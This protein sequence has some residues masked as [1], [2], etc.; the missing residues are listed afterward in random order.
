MVKAGIIQSITGSGII[1]A[2][3][4]QGQT[5]TLRQG[6]AVY[7]G[8]VLGT[9]GNISVVVAN[10]NGDQ[11]AS[12]A[13]NAR[14][15]MEE[16]MFAR[17][18]EK[19]STIHKADQIQAALDQGKQIADEE[20]AVGDENRFDSDTSDFHE[21]DRSAG[22]VE[23]RALGAGSQ[24]A[25]SRVSI[26]ETS[27]NDQIESL[28]AFGVEVDETNGLDTLS[29]KISVE[30][31]TAGGSLV[32]SADGATWDDTS[33]TLTDDLGRWQIVLDQATGS[34]TFTQLVAE[35]HGDDGNDH[36]S[37][38]EYAITVTATNNDGNSAE[39]EFKVGIRD[40]GPS[41]IA[42]DINQGDFI[43][44]NA[45]SD[46][47]SSDSSSD[48]VL[49]S[50]DEGDF[51]TA[52]TVL[53]VAE[54]FEADFGQDGSGSITYALALDLTQ[55]TD[56]VGSQVYAHND[57]QIM[58]QLVN[59]QIIGFEGDT[60]YFT[61]SINE[62]G[63]LEFDQLEPVKHFGI[64]A[65]EDSVSL[66]LNGISV[67]AVITDSD[68][69]T[70]TAA[71]D[72]SDYSFSILDDA[73]AA[74]DDNYDVDEDGT[75]IVDPL[76]VFAN[77]EMGGD[78]SQLSSYTMP[79]HGSLVLNEDGSFTYKPD[80]DFNGDD[81][82]TYTLTD[83]DGDSST[84]TVN[85]TVNEINDPPQ[86]LDKFISVDEANQSFIMSDAV[87]DPDD[88]DAELAITINN[89][90]EFGTLFYTDA[91][92]NQVEITGVIS[93][94]QA[95]FDSLIYVADQDA[96]QQE[97]IDFILGTTETRG[98]IS[99]WGT[100]DDKGYSYSSS[101]GSIKAVVTAVD[102]DG[103]AAKVGFQ[104]S[105]NSEKGVG[106]GVKGDIGNGQINGNK[107][108]ET[109]T[110]VLNFYEESN[111]DQLAS[112]TNVTLGFSGLGGYFN[113]GASQ[114]AHVHWVAKDA[115][116]NIVAQGYENK[117]EGMTGNKGEVDIEVKDSDGTPLSFTTLEVS[118]DGHA[119]GE[120]GYG[121]ATLKYV[122][123]SKEVQDSF[124]YTVTDDDG[125]SSTGTVY[126][127]LDALTGVNNTIEG[128]DEDNVIYGTDGNDIIYG[129]DGDDVIF[130]LEGEDII[131]G[132]SGTDTLVVTESNLDFSSL[133]AI[134][135]EMEAIHVGQDGEN[136]TISL[137]AQDVLSMSSDNLF[138][139]SGG[140]EDE[141]TLVLQQSDNWEQSGTN[142][143]TAE[144]G[145]QEVSINVTDINV[146]YDD[147][148]NPVSG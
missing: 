49:L 97:S 31:G 20:T 47:S 79:E 62:E 136:Q 87:S 122:Q 86:A 85:I 142:T 19:D 30:F 125:Q 32:L 127:D 16:S 43:D 124:E 66:S 50:V 126:F 115:D 52:Q 40:D 3:S 63:K 117:P 51:S 105:P 24:V 123:V 36:D 15:L 106:L 17:V 57:Q 37:I 58:L 98:S 75:L 4:P 134:I 42:N 61:I 112:V 140:G 77:D 104:N 38:V 139:I 95:E 9:T 13:D 14:V 101:V 69:D 131:D 55:G 82:Y 8:E 141:D 92:D 5:R 35:D 120:L 83:A 94:S 68:G 102:S 73:P 2:I 143:Y 6:D 119:D 48:K 99:E 65:D 108:G 39:F 22:N 93:L 89:L 59:G 26:D 41:I 53:P 91:S 103:D 33:N 132:G 129:N 135:S 111:T 80:T 45:R 29:G 137:T 118:V 7:L 27:Y 107:N 148:G 130:G 128:N 12:L 100:T 18:A 11:V 1:T 133:S 70:D 56:T 138:E 34:Y 116:G 96:V 44:G 25:A 60:I 81:S 76:G 72:L 23:P 10:E 144:V 109:E 114:N 74:G 110:L 67:N 84:A 71:L 78:G 54:F 146:V 145:G 28:S 88:I 121:S 147:Q 46:E 21:G 90:P 64:D 113:D